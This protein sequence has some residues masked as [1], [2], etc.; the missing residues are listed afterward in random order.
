MCRSKKT[1]VCESKAACQKIKNF[2]GKK[3]I[4][5]DNCTLKQLMLLKV[6]DKHLPS[7]LLKQ[8]NKM[9]LS[10]AILEPKSV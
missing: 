4:E 3:A 5:N 6:K 7:G 1:S 10:Q 8:A 2:C 9:L